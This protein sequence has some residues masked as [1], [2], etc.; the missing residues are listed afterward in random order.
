LKTATL[1]ALSLL[2]VAPRAA[3]AEV[4]VAQPWSPAPAYLPPAPPENPPPYPD[5]QW[6]APSADAADATVAQAP[7]QEPT[8]P[9]PSASGAW[10]YT[11]QYG[12]VWAPCGDQYVDY[13]GDDTLDGASAYEYVFLPSSGWTWLT[14]PWALGLGT[15]PYF[16]SARP[17]SF[18]WYR[19]LGV[20]SNGWGRYPSERLGVASGV[21]GR[22]PLGAGAAAANVP[23]RA[24]GG[25]FHR[26]LATG[27]RPV[28]SSRGTYHRPPR[29]SSPSRV[30]GGGRSAGRGGHR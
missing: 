11:D 14:A 6:D 17:E 27:A 28:A 3:L 29:P 12:W 18:G 21:R 2:L 16:G 8:S 25:G 22:A 23:A 24:S 5:N 4:E 9:S 7:S 10:V 13:L 20:A 1:A 26:A 19:A 30:A 15:Y